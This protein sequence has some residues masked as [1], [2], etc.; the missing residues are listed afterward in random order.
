MTRQ[1]FGTVLMTLGCAT[2]IA[3]AISAQPIRERLLSG[4]TLAAIFSGLLALLKFL[5]EYIRDNRRKRLELFAE[6]R[7]EFRKNP[8]FS[9]I[10][11]ALDEY[12]DDSN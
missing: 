1:G 9:D 2:L 3:L 10:F 4:L 5:F 11:E 8:N 6:L 7:R 12:A